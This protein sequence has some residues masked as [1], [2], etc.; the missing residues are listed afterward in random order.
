[1]KYEMYEHYYF[2]YFKVNNSLIKSSP[3]AHLVYNSI[4]SPT[5]NHCSYLYAI[6]SL[7]FLSLQFCNLSVYLFILKQYSIVLSECVFCMKKNH[8]VYFL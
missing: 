4:L 7:L 2:N 5:G 1:M 3:H 8:R 6:C